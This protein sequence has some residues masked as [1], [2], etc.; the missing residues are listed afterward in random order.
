MAAQH[1]AQIVPEHERGAWGAA[2]FL[3]VFSYF[4]ITLTPLSDL[5]PGV[6]PAWGGNSSTVNQIVVVAMFA[7]LL[8]TVWRDPLR[9]MLM[10]PRWLLL[11]TLVWFSAVSV[12][13]SDPNAAFRRI[14]FAVL[15]CVAAN[16]VLLLPK[17]EAQFA[18]LLGAGILMVLGLSYIGVMF[19]PALAIHQATDIV[20]RTL[21]GDWR[22]H[23][24]H[25]NEAA[26]AMAIAVFCG[27]YIASVWSRVLGW[28]IVLLA[29]VFV[30]NAGGKTAAGFLP[31]IFILSWAFERWKGARVPIAVGGVALLNVLVVG[32]SVFAGL[33]NFVTALGID[34]T[35]T[36][37]AGVWQLAMSAIAARPL[38]GYGF[39]SFWQT[40]K[41]L[42]GAGQENWAATAA[43]SH[44]AYLEAMINAGVPGLLLV[45]IWL[46]LLPIRD[47]S[48]AKDGGND[49]ALTRLFIRIWLY[50]LFSAVLESTFFFNTGPLWFSMLL[51]VFG[52]RMQ[53]R[54]SL[55]AAPA[56]SAAVPANA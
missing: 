47:A 30:F 44:N 54:A 16:A 29:A 48:Q 37:R 55:V 24:G 35:F 1:Q 7:L 3:L 9:G 17:T 2:L 11:V 38:T 18:R 4:W 42:Y 19:F 56:S 43:H 50:S 26:A 5:G 25:K 49:P 20:E 27:L 53:A 10:Q 28:L 31:A 52:L 41:L 21:A 23:F 6:D 14:I 46:V 22:G 36:D 15:V 33:R 51:A 32:S 12:P 39:Q 45:V 13:A 34:A 40:D 8:L